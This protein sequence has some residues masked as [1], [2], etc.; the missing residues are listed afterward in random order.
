MSVRVGRRKRIP[1]Q[2]PHLTGENLI[3]L[4]TFPFVK[5]AGTAGRLFPGGSLEK[6][7]AEKE[8]LT[9]NFLFIIL[10]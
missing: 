7:L 8:D 9:L 3:L 1:A 6:K 2:W 5:T 10:T 4:G